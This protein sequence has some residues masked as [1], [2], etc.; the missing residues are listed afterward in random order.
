MEKL[1]SEIDYQS[2]SETL[3]RELEQARLEIFRMRYHRQTVKPDFMS[4]YDFLTRHALVISTMSVGLLI[5][6][7]FIDRLKAFKE[8]KNA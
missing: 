6:L 4:V 1:L 8:R 2:L 3:Q 5:V 7:S